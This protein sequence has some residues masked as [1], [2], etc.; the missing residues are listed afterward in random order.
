VC[1]HVPRDATI[2]IKNTGADYY[3]SWPTTDVITSGMGKRQPLMVLFDTFREYDGW[4]R[5]FCYMKRWGQVVQ[6]CRAGGVTGINAWGA[7]SPGGIWPDW[8]PG[9][10]RNQEREEKVP[11]SWAGHWNAF[12]MFTRGFTPGQ[13]NPYLLAR[14]AWN[15]N[16]DVEQIARDFAALQ[17]GPA[18]ARAAAEALMATEDAFAQEYLGT[19]QEVTHPCHLKWTMVFRPQKSMMEKA[20][21]N[22]TL[23]QVLKS[24]ARGLKHVRKME[25]TFAGTDPAKAPNLKRYELFKEGIGKT[26]LFLRTFY[27]WRE[28]WWRDRSDRDLAGAAKAA[29]A[30]ALREA[31]ARL[32]PL[33]DQ[34]QKYPEEAGHWHITNRYG[35][36]KVVPNDTFPSWYTPEDTTM[37][38]TTKEFR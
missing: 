20:Y 4:S 19:R 14:L 28:C 9:Y 15:P 8:K 7:W 31:K 27:L 32:M 33:F 10:L 25:V 29:N 35:K 5:L 30:A 24:N 11:V 34:W 3:L 18:N 16:A 37:E 6:A 13:S 12:R 17:L 2:A 23:E 26:A 22:T 1:R 36:P 21:R 38:S